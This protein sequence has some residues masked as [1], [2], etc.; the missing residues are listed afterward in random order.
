MILGIV[1]GIVVGIVIGWIGGVLSV[2]YAIKK[3][4]PSL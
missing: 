4:K 2:M 3:F 1:I